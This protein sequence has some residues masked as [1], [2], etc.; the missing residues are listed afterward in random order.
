MNPNK[1]AVD[2]KEDAISSSKLFFASTFGLIKSTAKIEAA[3]NALL[4]D[5]RM[6]KEFEN[7]DELKEFLEL[8]KYNVVGVGPGIGL[9]RATRLMLKV[10]VESAKV[11]I[12]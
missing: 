12:V 11:P 6:F 7:S 1:T 2:V 10:L 3:H 9:N 8:E 5:F 4:A